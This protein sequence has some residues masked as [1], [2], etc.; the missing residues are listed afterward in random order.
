MTAGIALQPVPDAIQTLKKVIMF[1]LLSRLGVRIP[2]LSWMPA[3]DVTNARVTATL[4]GL[5]GR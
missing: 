4:I 5:N 2:N 3:V 1:S